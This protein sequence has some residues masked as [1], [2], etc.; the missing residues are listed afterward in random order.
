M[1]GFAILLAFNLL[2]LILHN[3]GMPLPANVLG[4]IL[5]A[6]ALFAGIVRVEW[7]DDAADLLLRHLMLFFVPTI[8][9]VV[10][11]GPMLKQQWLSIGGG[12]M[13]S[14]LA[15]MIVTALVARWLEA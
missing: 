2:G 7:V 4:M 11:F 13:A 1:P 3:I 6:A 14:L 5:F 12:M 9:A 15:S 10:T 8:V